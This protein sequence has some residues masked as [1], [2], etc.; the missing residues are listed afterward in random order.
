MDIKPIKTTEDYKAALKK[1][2][3]VFDAQMKR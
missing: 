1:L 3:I 2:E